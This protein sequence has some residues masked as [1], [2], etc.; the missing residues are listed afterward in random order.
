MERKFIR[1]FD[2]VALVFFVALAMVPVALIA[3]G[4]LIQ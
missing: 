1:V 4:G 2:T 3:S